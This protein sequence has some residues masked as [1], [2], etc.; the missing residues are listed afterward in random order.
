MNQQEKLELLAMA[1]AELGHSMSQAFV[2]SS[3]DLMTLESIATTRKIGDPEEIL[4]DIKIS[5][6]I[7]RHYGK[8]VTAVQ[9][10]TYEIF[11]G[12]LDINKSIEEY[13]N[14]LNTMNSVFDEDCRLRF[15]TNLT[16]NLP[17]ANMQEELYYL[18]LRNTITNSKTHFAKNINISTQLLDNYIVT[19]IKDDGSGI[20]SEILPNVT[21]PFVTG[22]CGSG[23][24]LASSNLILK[25]V[26]GKLDIDSILGKYTSVKVLIP[27]YK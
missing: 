1:G 21:K 16:Q 8:I 15:N 18:I 20:P 24:G 25:Q 5:K 9:H 3:A 10:I 11:N 4:S 2:G 22:G 19:T 6:K 13:V 23:I 26:G 7:N 17:Y 27:T 12:K 14:Y